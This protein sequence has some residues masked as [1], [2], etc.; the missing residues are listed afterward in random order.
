MKHSKPAQGQ[1]LSGPA[2]GALNRKDAAHPP[3]HHG[4]KGKK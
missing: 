1:K 3:K 4:G 2:H